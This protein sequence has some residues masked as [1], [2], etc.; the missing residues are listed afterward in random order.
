MKMSNYLYIAFAVILVIGCGEKIYTYN[1]LIDIG[2]TKTSEAST[3]TPNLI[4]EGNFQYSI[5]EGNA[6]ELT[7]RYP[8]LLDVAVSVNPKSR[9]IEE[10]QVFQEAH[11]ELLDD[12]HK[13]YINNIFIGIRKD[14][15][16]SNYQRVCD[17]IKI[18]LK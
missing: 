12:Y 14:S 15:N 10:W 9:R 17:F 18:E 4:W 7:R 3:E 11:S 8:V 13:C 16:F 1:D 6:M 5:S 2:F